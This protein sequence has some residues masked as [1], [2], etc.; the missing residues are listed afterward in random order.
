MSLKKIINNLIT[1]SIIVFIFLYLFNNREILEEVN[2]NWLFILG[3]LFFSIA[4][5][6]ISSLIDI[7]LFEN[8]NVNLKFYESLNLTIINTWKHSCAYESWVW[9][10][11]LL[12]KNKAWIIYL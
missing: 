9:I 1:L 7:K 6:L 4:R 3:I 11:S 10:K 5:Y 8:V 2:Y 12:S